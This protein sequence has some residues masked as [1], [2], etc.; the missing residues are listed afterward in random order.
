MVLIGCDFHSSWQ[1]VS[2]LDRESGETGDQKLVHEPE[3]WKSFTGS[4]RLDRRSAWKLLGTASG[5]WKW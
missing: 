1:Q 4:F 5:L 2:W 3:R